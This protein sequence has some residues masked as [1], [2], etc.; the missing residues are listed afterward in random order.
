[1]STP[2]D[3]L[4][5][6]VFISLLAG[7]AMMAVWFTLSLR[8]QDALAWF[9]L[10]AAADIALLERWTRH[11]ERRSPAWVAPLATVACAVAS[12]WLITALS[13]SQA[14]GF[15][16][17]DSIHQMGSGLF[18]QLLQL[19]LAPQEWILLAASPPLAYL[20]AD[21]GRLS[22]RRRSP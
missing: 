5:K 19:R 8:L 15:D 14:G 10:V 4:F 22:V 6:P 13:V 17:R 12:L 11:P 9:G 16:F 2:R 3:A 20:L 7:L 18:A 1:M 21:A